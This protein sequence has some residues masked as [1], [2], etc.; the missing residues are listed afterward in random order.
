MDDPIAV[1]PAPGLN[2][3]SVGMHYC[4]TYLQAPS[5]LFAS[6]KLRLSL[7][8]LGTKSWLKCLVVWGNVF[9]PPLVGA[10]ARLIPCYSTQEGDSGILMYEAA[11]GT[12]CASSLAEAMNLLRFWLM[13]GTVGVLFLIGPCL[14][15]ILAAPHPKWPSFDHDDT[16]GFLVAGYAPACRWWEAMVLTRKSAIYLVAMWFPMSWAPGAH[17]IYLAIIVALSEVVHNTVRPYS[18]SH[19][20]RLEGQA[21][22]IALICLLLVAS[23][24]VEWPFRPYTMYV[25]SCALLTLLTTGAYLYFFILYIRASAKAQAENSADADE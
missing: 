12:P 15:L 16:I 14:W 24:L 3:E 7:L 17:L 5:V 8:L 6:V 20:N 1:A 9:I 25:I 21:L 19:L 22:G 23:L 18:S 11:F 4:S 13:I 2:F 10:A